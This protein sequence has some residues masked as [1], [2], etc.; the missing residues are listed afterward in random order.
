[1]TSQFDGKVVAIT[2]AAGNLGGNVVRAFAGHGAQVA[3]IDL[4]ADRLASTIATLDG[5]PNRFAAF[6]GDLSQ[7]E[8]VQTLIDQIVAH[9]GQIDVLI[10]TVGG[11]DAGKPV[12]EAGIEV[13]DKMMA[14]NVRPL[15]LMGAAVAQ[16]MLQR[17]IAGKIVFILARSGLKGLKNQGAYT[18]S[19]AAAIRIMES[20][21]AELKDHGIN[22]NGISPS[23]I[24]TAPNR[25]SMPDADF[26]KWVSPQHL[27]DALLFLASDQANALHGTN[28][29]VYNRS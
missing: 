24:D 2:G 21:S 1:M 5:D 19:K 26:S 17:G 15:Y 3:L 14:L 12:H 8:S 10:H 7:P 9:F 6:P 22:V 11:Y 13:L 29:E 4:S 18:A 28:L 16:H 27:A 20:M 25:Q 23:I